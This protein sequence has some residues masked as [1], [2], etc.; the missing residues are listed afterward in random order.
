MVEISTT[1]PKAAGEGDKEGCWVLVT[2]LMK[3]RTSEAKTFCG[4]EKVLI[5]EAVN[6]AIL[7]IVCKKTGD[8]EPTIVRDE[9]AAALSQGNGPKYIA[10]LRRAAG[11]LGASKVL[12][13][14][15]DPQ[16]QAL[17]DSRLLFSN[18]TVVRAT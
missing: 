4:G 17:A 6:L 9:T 13:V 11:M 16:L 14:T 12:Y 18:G 7:A 3:Q 15:H 10:M 8:R 1:R 5:A 2:D